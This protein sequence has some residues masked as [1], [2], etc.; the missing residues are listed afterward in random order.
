ML[1]VLLLLGDGSLT[2]EE[3]HDTAVEELQRQMQSA[4]LADSL[5]GAQGSV[6]ARHFGSVLSFHNVNA[7]TL[8]FLANSNI[9]RSLSVDRVADLVLREVR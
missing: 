3:L 6:K 8:E 2:E 5:E 9:V 1:M 4:G 7:S